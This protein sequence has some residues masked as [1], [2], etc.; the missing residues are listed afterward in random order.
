[1]ILSIEYQGP[2]QQNLQGGWNT[3]NQQAGNTGTG[4]FN[5]PSSLGY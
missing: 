2:V 5:S 1:V 3:S 4:G